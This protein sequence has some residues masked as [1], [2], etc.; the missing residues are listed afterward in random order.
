MKV[1]F[2]KSACVVI[3]HGSTRVLC[4]PWL[5]DGI[6]Y[7]SWY[8]YPPLIFRPE[9]FADVDFIYISHIHPDHLD[10]ASLARLPKHIPVII[11]E[12][13]E[14]FVL[15]LLS[16]IGFQVIHEISH[17]AAFQLGP[18]FTIE[19]FAADNCDP[20]MCG[21]YFQCS[22]PTPYKKTMQIDSMAL[23]RGGDKTVVNT[24]DC[25]YGLSKTVCD[26]ILKK[27]PSIDFL[28]VGYSG[29][30]AYPQCF[31]NLPD[32]LKRQESKAHQ[33]M[34]L[35]Q[36]VSYLKHFKPEA[37]M[38]FAGQYVLGG[39]LASLNQFTSPPK[40]EELPDV[41]STLM[42]NHGIDSRFVLLDSGAYY[43]VDRR[44]SSEDFHPINPQERQDYIENVLAQKTFTY[45]EDDFEPIDL[46]EKLREAHAKMHAR[47]QQYGAAHSDWNIYIDAGQ[48]FVYHVPLL[49]EKAV[50][51]VMRNEFVTPYLRIG[52]DYRLLTRILERKAHW[53]NAEIGSHLHFYREPNIYHRSIHMFMSYFHC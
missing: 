13:A 42:Q 16:K 50:S 27:H 3:E 19:V 26:A 11:H 53:N 25:P 35:E 36:C 49:E 8:H 12:Y 4:D 18:D 32:H 52:L 10:P 34:K 39:K 47:Q 29:A 41:F 38:P 5:T 15:S 14:K 33:T 6:Y 20:A 22:V 40:M 2:I 24:N 45:E 28:L 1:Q 23:F 7:G 30:A 9:D 43:D 17:G 46:T 48:E 21:R 31:E 51:K 37:F 44:Q